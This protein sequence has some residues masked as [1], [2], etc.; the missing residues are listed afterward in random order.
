[1]ALESHSRLR[2][3]DRLVRWWSVGLVLALVVAGGALAGLRSLTA[4]ERAPALTDGDGHSLT[5]RGFSASGSAKSAP[6][7]M[8]DL[9]PGDID[10]ENAD[11]GTNFVRFLISWRSIE[12]RPGHYDEDY[13]DDVATRVRWYADRGY[14]VM[15]DMH[16]D[17][18][19]NQ[20]VPGQDVGNGAPGWATYTDDLPIGEH[21]MWELYYLDPGVMRAFDNFWG[22]TREHPELRRHYVN[23]WK[24][25]AK[26]FADNPAVIAYDLMN[27][28]YGG[29]LQGPAFEAGPLTS[30]Y[31]ST[32]EAIRTVDDS[33]WL[34]LEPQAMGVNW[35][36][37]SALGRVDDPRDGSPRIAYC[38][39]L[40]PLPMDLGGGY[41]GTTASM[42]RSSV[43][44]WLGNTLRT[45][46]RLGDVPVVLGEFGLDTTLP[47][48]LDYV[49]TV[50][51][52][53]DE[54]G[55]AVAY[56]SRDPGSW[57]PYDVKGNPRNL[58]GA[59]ARPYP[60]SV[61]GAVGAVQSDRHRLT[62]RVHPSGDRRASV[63][64]PRDFAPGAGR[65]E[66]A[67][68]GAEVTGWDGARHVLRL[69]VDAAATRVS[70][71]A[72]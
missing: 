30:L 34:C 48:A 16:Q 52:L 26:R 41:T 9:R 47:G 40:Y 36:T 10:R 46:E 60:R 38:P 54:H 57:G 49:R 53:A 35:G 62:F 37:P 22:T 29:S 19:G 70:I 12:P 24:V 23:A 55:F 20:I 68:C 64:L 21:S 58:V 2:P 50:Y 66:V 32:A 56:W 1:M 5:L 27:E 39:H 17:L 65:P 28:P 72:R 15:L 45:A 71:R 63:Y 18:Y 8:P 13:L 69:T 59:L 67:V 14:H 31:R 43:Q 4:P 11:M 7:G 61:S 6:D 25:V 51:D 42:V 44:T 33:T 3:G